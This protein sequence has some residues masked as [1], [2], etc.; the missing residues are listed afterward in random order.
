MTY[1]TECCLLFT[2]L[3]NVKRG[4]RLTWWRFSLKHYFIGTTDG[5]NIPYLFNV[6]TLRTR[7]LV[8]LSKRLFPFSHFWN[9][10]GYFT[11]EWTNTRLVC[12]DLN[13]FFIVD[14][15]MVID[16]IDGNDGVE[17]KWLEKDSLTLS[18]YPTQ[19]TAKNEQR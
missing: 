8:L 3:H 5:L 6:L 15:N 7:G 14:S 2:D 18:K 13:A 9:F 17:M 12:T 4:C 1:M 19:K 10:N 16:M 11:K